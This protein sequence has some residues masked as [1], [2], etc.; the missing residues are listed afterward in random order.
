M[1]HP[2]RWSPRATQDLQFL[3][4]FIAICFIVYLVTHK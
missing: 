2:F 4:V 3:A 1:K